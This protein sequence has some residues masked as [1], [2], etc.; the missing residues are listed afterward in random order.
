MISNIGAK[1][2][3]FG[4]LGDISS[5]STQHLIFTTCPGTDAYMLSEAVEEKLVYTDN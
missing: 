3:D 5:Q 1:V 2:S 4:I